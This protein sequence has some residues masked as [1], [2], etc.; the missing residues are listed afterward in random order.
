MLQELQ[1]PEPIET[2][3]PATQP[4]PDA[5]D[6]AP[7]LEDEFDAEFDAEFD[8]LED[9]IGEAETGTLPDRP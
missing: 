8:D 5:A 9:I 3:E 4:D 7:T 1:Q 6:Q 2:I